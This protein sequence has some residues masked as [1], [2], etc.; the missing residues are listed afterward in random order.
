MALYAE[1]HTLRDIA[2]DKVRFNSVYNIGFALKTPATSI[3]WSGGE[4]FSFRKRMGPKSFIE[5]RDVS[6]KDFNQSAT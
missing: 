4:I 3:R 5:R 1:H 2:V 6:C